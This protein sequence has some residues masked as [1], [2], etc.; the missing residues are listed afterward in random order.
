MIGTITQWLPPT[1]AYGPVTCEVCGCRLMRDEDTGTDAWR[2]FPSSDP[3]R[4]ARGCRPS[5]VAVLHDRSGRAL[6][7]LAA[8]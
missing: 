8:A 7:D 1:E 3:G 5:C 2:H 4:D 6:G